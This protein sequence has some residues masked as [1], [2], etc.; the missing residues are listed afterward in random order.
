MP[1]ESFDPAVE[2]PSRHIP[3][4]SPP[5]GN[6]GPVSGDLSHVHRSHTQCAS[7]VLGLVLLVLATACGG[8]DDDALADL[9]PAERE[10][11]E[12]VE[13]SGCESCHGDGGRGGIAPSWV[14]LPSSERELADGSTVVADS[15]YLRRSIMEPQA[16]VVAGYTLRMPPNGLTDAEVDAVIT[17]IEGLSP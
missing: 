7:V 2:F 5:A 16:D 6:L 13:A 4:D 3:G 11:F 10:G 15:A 17:Y 9:S 12:L 1:E 8:G 14:G